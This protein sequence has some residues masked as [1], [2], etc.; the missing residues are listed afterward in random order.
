[1][2]KLQGDTLISLAERVVQGVKN[3]R[4]QALELFP[5]L[6]AAISSK[7]TIKYQKGKREGRKGRKIVFKEWCGL[8]YLF[9]CCCCGCCCFCIVCFVICLLLFCRRWAYG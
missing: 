7:K 1:V 8:D 3:G 5:K 6:L 4:H 2:D 9:W